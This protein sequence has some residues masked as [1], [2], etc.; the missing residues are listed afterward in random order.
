MSHF[1][2]IPKSLS[3]MLN[4][5]TL[6]VKQNFGLNQSKSIIIKQVILANS[7]N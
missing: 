6:Y 3:K 1:Y 4:Y 2:S 5:E 7:K